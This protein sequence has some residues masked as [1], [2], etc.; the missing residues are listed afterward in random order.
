M[1][2]R[3]CGYF[4]L[5][6]TLLLRIYVALMW[7]DRNSGKLIVHACNTR[8]IFTRAKEYELQ[9]FHRNAIKA[10]WQHFLIFNFAGTS[11]NQNI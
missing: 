7:P 4:Q 8:E 2:V 9:Y 11:P 5:R 3:C 1:F 6:A 10:K